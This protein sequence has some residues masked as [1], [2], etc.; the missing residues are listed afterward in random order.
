MQ[1]I[2]H[3]DELFLRVTIEWASN[4]YNARYKSQDQRTQEHFGR[5]N[6]GQIIHC[7]SGN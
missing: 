4:I 6:I 5:A 1:L 3:I 7:S 2:Q